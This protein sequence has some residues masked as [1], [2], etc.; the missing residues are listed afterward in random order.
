MTDSDALEE[1]A[2]TQE[3]LQGQAD[4]VSRKRPRDACQ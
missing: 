3:E 4:T 1:E 2:M